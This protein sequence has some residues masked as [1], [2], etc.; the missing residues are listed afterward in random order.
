[1]A[2]KRDVSGRRVPCFETSVHAKWG[3]T[4]GA[5][6]TVGGRMREGNEQPVPRRVSGLSNTAA[7]L[8]VAIP[9]SI[10]FA[11]GCGS[12]N[13]RDLL[14]CTSASPGS[15]QVLNLGTL[16][17]GQPGEILLAYQAGL[18]GMQVGDTLRLELPTAWYNR[19]S[20]PQRENLT[21]YQSRDPDKANYFGVLNEG[22]ANRFSY[23][24]KVDRRLDGRFNRFKSILEIHL[25]EGEVPAGERI[26]LLVRGW[27]EGQDFRVPEAAGSGWIRGEFVPASVALCPALIEPA[28]LSVQAGAP[29]EL[30]VALPSVGECGEWMTLK[31]CL[32]DEYYNPCPAWHDPVTLEVPEQ[33]EG[34]PI[35]M[36][37]EELNAREGGLVTLDFRVADPGC[38]R[39]RALT[40]GLEAVESNPVRIS[41]GRPGAK[42]FW[43]DL[44][45]HSEVSMDG[46][47]EGPFSYAR[48]VSLLDF[49]ALT[50]HHTHEDNPF[51]RRTLLPASEWEAIQQDVSDYYEPGSFVTLLAFENSATSPSGHQ[52]VYYPTEEG[53][54]PLGGQLDKTWQPVSPYGAFI[55]Q[56]H[57]G[58]IWHYHER[59]AFLSRLYAFFIEGSWVR[60]SAYPRIPRPA[61]EIYSLHGQSEY[62]NPLD[63][64][65]YENCGLGLP[66]EGRSEN[67][68][69]GI[70]KQGRH[71]ARNAWA[72]G[73]KLGVV[74][75]SD[76]H[77]AQ[78]GKAGGGLTAVW[79]ESL[80]RPDVFLAINGRRTYAT[81]GDRIILDFRV[82][83]VPM[84]SETTLVGFPEITVDVVG[85]APIDSLQ[86]MKYELGTGPWEVL[87]D[88]RSQPNEVNLST[89]DTFFSSDTLYYVRLEQA[90]KTHGRPVRA[91]SSPIW[92]RAAK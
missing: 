28:R 30:V 20:C 13:P 9:S 86:I 71:Y 60:W 73:L 47:G 81:T 68:W 31:M 27:K 10:I 44:H 42:L 82:N 43:G 87:L 72:Q 35:Q 59:P 63:S 67:C 23:S 2:H 70:S 29:V 1:M 39:V 83:G 92:V 4:R 36:S 24:T 11:V 75:G 16:V 84:G 17:A 76:D 91:W 5:L 18:D 8:K 57:P 34:I 51:A 61:L 49:F 3:L 80:T 64:L 52:N 14:A 62:Y 22:G 7:L 26:T 32:L 50:E 88:V 15:L 25:E 6:A 79:A 41:A 40:G 54:L 69:T 58:I 65:S 45:S 33:I 56:H 55:I 21:G 48:D 53:P 90:N 85:T 46:M 77:R 37:P 74:A 19:Y 12:N 89:E 78:P 66:R 38:Y